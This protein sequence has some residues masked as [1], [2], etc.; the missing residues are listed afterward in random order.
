MAP[1]ASRL[2][3]HV[4]CGGEAL[5]S[6]VRRVGRLLLRTIQ[7]PLKVQAH[8]PTDASSSHLTQPWQG[9]LLG[10][11]P[12]YVAFNFKWRRPPSSLPTPVKLLQSVAGTASSANPPA[13]V[14]APCAGSVEHFERLPVGRVPL[15]AASVV[16]ALTTCFLG[17]QVL[18]C[19]GGSHGDSFPYCRNTPTARLSWWWLRL[20]FETPSHPQTLCC[21]LPAEREGVPAQARHAGLLH[22]CKGR[23]GP[24]LSVCPDRGQ[25]APGPLPQ[26][27]R[28]GDAAGPGAPGRERVP[29]ATAAAA[30]GGGRR[31]GWR[32]V[33]RALGSLPCSPRHAPACLT[34]VQK[35][36]E[37]WTSI[38][39]CRRFTVWTQFS[40]EMLS[41]GIS[42]PRFQW[43]AGGALPP[44]GTGWH[45]DTACPGCPQQLG[46]VPAS[47]Q[48]GWV[49]SWCNCNEVHRSRGRRAANLSL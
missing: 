21:R 24:W 36:S 4:S 35:G 42:V 12:A 14:A 11:L 32:A 44:V 2:G 28:S 48:R 33:D 25:A 20:C 26:S 41:E 43:Q 30:A 15:L 22:S 13:G 39:S 29:H 16:T 49:F 37:T 8:F 10:L 34:P 47:G 46:A 19:R 23:A 3:R 45:G 6:T 18:F 38:S 9:G 1:C 27:P 31:R 17:C 5:W 7:D 40:P